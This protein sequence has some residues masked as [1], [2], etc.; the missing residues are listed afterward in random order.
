MRQLLLFALE[1]VVSLALNITASLFSKPQAVEVSKWCWLVVLIH[2]T[3]LIISTKRLEHWAVKLR[4]AFGIRGMFSYFL[5]AIICARLG[6]LY[7]R[8]INLVYARLFEQ[9]TQKVNDK[10]PT[11]LDLFLK[12]DFSNI[13][14]ITDS[15]RLALQR[16]DDGSTLKIRTQI[17]AADF[18]PESNS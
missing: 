5:I 14:R 6:I 15:D 10:P 7:S 1:I 4:A 2:A 16:K 8:S 9:A 11:L 3:Y 13:L 18:G 12:S 17:Y